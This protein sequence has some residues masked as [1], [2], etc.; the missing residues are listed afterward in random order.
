MT[1]FKHLLSYENKKSRRNFCGLSEVIGELFYLLQRPFAH[2]PCFTTERLMP[3]EP[4]AQP[5]RATTLVTTGAFGATFITRAT[6]VFG[7]TL[8]ITIAFGAT[9]ATGALG[10]GATGRLMPHLPFAHTTF[11][12]ATCA[13][14]GALATTLITGAFAGA[15]G[16]FATGLAAHL[17]FTHFAG[18]TTVR[19][20]PHLPLAQRDEATITFFAATGA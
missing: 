5:F 17:P 7:A 16:A 3:Q 19:F 1:S 11:R 2:P 12:T 4:F 9:F 14:A 6:R 10:A 8:L 20:I 15:I 13:K 18:V